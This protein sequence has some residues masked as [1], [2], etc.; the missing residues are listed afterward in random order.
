MNRTEMLQRL[1]AATVW[2][3]IIVGGGATGLGTA[4]DAAARGYKTLLVEQ[5]DFAKGT[6]SRSTK[7]V[8]GGVRY[9]AQ[10]NIKLVR[11][12]LKERGLLLKNAPHVTMPLSFVLP[13][14]SVW[15]KIYYGIGLKLY[16]MMA[17]EYGLG[18][19]KIIS[20]KKTRSNLPTINTKKL[21]GAIVYTDGQFDDAR[22]AINLAAT[23]VENGA[24][25]LNY[26]KLIKLLKT[27]TAANS[28]AN[29]SGLKNEKISGVIVNDEISGKHYE[30]NCKAVINATGVFTDEVLQLDDP[31][32][33][34]IV[35]PSQG[36]HLVLDKKFFPGNDAM[37]I[38]KTA[39][40]RV[41]FAV[42]WHDKVVVGTTDT[43]IGSHSLEPKPLEEEIEFVLYHINKYLDTVI[44]RTD[45]KAAFA[46]LRPLVKKGTSKKTALMPR[47]HTIIV[48]AGGLVTITGG[49]WTTYRKMAS[50][51]LDK[52]VA[53]ARLEKRS[54]STADL[55]IHGWVNANNKN[56]PLHFYGS[57]AVEIKNICREDQ[58][59]NELIHPSL[60]NIKAEIIWAV[61]NEMA[62]NVE[63]ILARRT[64]ILFLDAKAAMGSVNIV[65][66][67]MAK[68]MNKDK[69]W[70][71]QQ[72][73]DFTA[74]AKQYLL[75]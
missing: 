69:D 42:P 49:K 74:L 63:D 70:I 65:A 3:I 60:P 40:G 59:L 9:L 64:R 68:E 17:G 14:Y 75:S 1:D 43:P 37:M 51:V 56:D 72:I 50:E 57:D 39:D 71:Q 55:K 18:K 44:K 15:Q 73:N 53:V 23:A 54:C 4:V 62:M 29:G 45:V 66:S 21:T 46:G 20:S 19:T 7:L 26:C 33:K 27:P 36:I 52:A 25:V 5:H 22:L 47:D 12:A 61:R 41:L 13:C 67:I 30:L 31:S 6:S 28:P 34:N 38:P 2:D 24:T 35:S 8:H 10:G 58:T 11:E 48:S 32:A 16:D